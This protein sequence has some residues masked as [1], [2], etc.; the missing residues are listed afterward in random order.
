MKVDLEAEKAVLREIHAKTR[1]SNST[2]VEDEMS[3]IYDETFLIPPKG[4]P[5]VGNDAIKSLIQDSVKSSILSMGD[6][7]KGHTDFWMSASGDLAVSRGHFKVTRQE[8]KGQVVDEG[9]Y[10]TIF[11][12]VDGKWKLLGEMWNSL[13]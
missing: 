12:K 1:V 10:I 8:S 9:Y 13:K 11:R 6:P 5:I 4:K 7:R 2:N 3:Y